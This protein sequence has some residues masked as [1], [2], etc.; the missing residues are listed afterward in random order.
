MAKRVTFQL[1]LS[2]GAEVLQR[3]AQPMI[4]KSGEAIA[5]RANS[6][7]REISSKPPKITSHTS[8]G[9]IK[10]GARAISVVKGDGDARDAYIA[11]EAI[12]KSLDA[13]KV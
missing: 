5:S 10:R 6:M 2:G 3:M 11:S 4:K 7:A 9:T 1:D 8:V 13:G 12:R